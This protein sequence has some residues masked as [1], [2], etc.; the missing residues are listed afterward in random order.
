MKLDGQAAVVSGAA[1]GL[2]AASAKA[3]AEAGAKVAVFD[4]NLEGAA[5]TAAAIGGVAIQ[6]DV[7]DADSAEAAMRDARDVHGP[8]RIAVCC[9][10]I[11]PPAKIVGRNGVQPL[12]TFAK[13]IQVNLLGTFNVMRL[14]VADM[15]DLEPLDTGERGVIVNTASVAAYEGQIGQCAYAASKGGVAAMTLPAARE[16]ARS[17]IRVLAIAPGTFETP[18]LL[19]L[20]D[21]VQ[22]SLAASVPFPSRLGDPAEFASLVLH[23]VGNVMMN[24]EV[25]RLDGALRMPPI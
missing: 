12:D 1:S 14:A 11:A 8:A 22:E 3:L 2:G 10:G 16:L 7:S 23:M 4:M 19:G 9:A 18:M 6:C 21:E 17:G 24:G 20:P 15:M 13:T 5:E 25:V